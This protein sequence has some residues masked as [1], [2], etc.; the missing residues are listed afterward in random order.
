MDRR[1]PTTKVL[2]TVLTDLGGAAVD[3]GKFFA[4][5]SQGYGSAFRRGGSGYVA[6]LKRYQR[7]RDL[8]AT[9]RQLQYRRYVA[10]KK[11]GRRLFISLT[12]KGRAAT[13]IHRFKQAKPNAR[14]YY[15]VVVFD[16]PVSQGAA[17]KQLRLLLKQ[18]GFKF[19]QQS[20]WVSRVDTYD[21]VVE[22]V[23]YVKLEPWVNV[24]R[25]TDFLH[26]PST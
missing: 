22:F 3:I 10:A 15:T 19:L 5:L 18:G 20:V 9:L 17:R 8:G 16:V 12:P 26:P 4:A 1:M 11:V 25:A 7:E 23:R 24:C 14:G 13:L 2:L 21:A 6:E